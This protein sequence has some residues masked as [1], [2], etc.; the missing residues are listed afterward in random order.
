M[1]KVTQ[2]LLHCSKGFEGERACIY[3]YIEVRKESHERYINTK[4][5]EKYDR[6]DRGLECS[7]IHRSNGDNNIYQS[8]N[9]DKSDLYDIKVNQIYEKPLNPKAIWREGTTLIVGDSMLNGL[10][11]EKLRN[12]KVKSIPWSIHRGLGLS[13][14]SIATKETINRNYSYRDKEFRT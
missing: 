1:P 12:C 6:I 7:S 10:E 5:M 11:E 13:L 2:K 9:A 8:F 3:I 14:E 4:T